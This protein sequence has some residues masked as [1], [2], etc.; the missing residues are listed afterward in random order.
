[1]RHHPL[2]ELLNAFVAAGLALEH[3]AEL[4]DRPVPGILA[5]RARKPEGQ[6]SPCLLAATAFPPSSHIR[7]PAAQPWRARKDSAPRPADRNIEKCPA[8]RAQA[9]SCVTGW[10]RRCQAVCSGGG[11]G[12]CW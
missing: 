4:G 10:C 7:R 2:A 11:P 3:V 8:P 6:R 1:M 5:I 12:R 9:R